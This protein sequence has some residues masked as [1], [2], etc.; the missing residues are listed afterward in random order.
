[1]VHRGAVPFSERA[2]LCPAPRRPTSFH[3]WVHAG[4]RPAPRRP[5]S[6]HL[7]VHAGLRP[8]PRRPTSFHFWVHAGL[9]PAPRRPTSFHLCVHAGLCPAPRRPTSFHLL[10][11][12]GLRAPRPRQGTR[13]GGPPLVPYNPTPLPRRA[14]RACTREHV[15]DRPRPAQDRGRR[16]CRGPCCGLVDVRGVSRAR[17]GWCAGDRAFTRRGRVTSLAPRRRAFTVRKRRAARAVLPFLSLSLAS[18]SDASPTSEARRRERNRRRARSAVD[19]PERG[20]VGR[21]TREPASPVAGEGLHQPL[22]KC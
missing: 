13:G 22:R 10:V 14:S 18:P 2:G 5:T 19:D 16:R 15:A 8:A 1:M 7:C 17:G 9:R 20:E 11:H 4:L 12:A 21:G 3:F 6:F